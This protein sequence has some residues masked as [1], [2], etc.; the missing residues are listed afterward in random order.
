[1]GW[2]VS[3]VDDMVS[4]CI[5]QE[6]VFR[7]P[8]RMRRIQAGK[9]DLDDAECPLNAVMSEST[10]PGL[11]PFVLPLTAKEESPWKSYDR[12]HQTEL[13]GP[14]TVAERIEP[15]SGLVV[16]K[17]FSR[18]NAESR[19]SMLRQ[20]SDNYCQLYR[21]LSLRRYVIYDL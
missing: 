8:R 12:S 4:L 10:K 7:K 13:G 5:R 15:A 3:I 17:E 9:S 2:R 16:V 19:L 11:Q 1:M 6:G 21:N 18:A 20:V 14:V